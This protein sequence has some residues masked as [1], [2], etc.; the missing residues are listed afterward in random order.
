MARAT[1][2]DYYKILGVKTDATH[3]EIKKRYRQLAL[4]HHPDQNNNSKK[5]EENFKILSEAHQTLINKKKRREYDLS[6]TR[7]GSAPRRDSWGSDWQNSAYGNY[8]SPPG[9]ESSRSNE[10]QRQRAGSPFGQGFAE[11]DVPP[12]PNRPMGGFDL[13]FMIEVPLTLVALGGTLPYSY[14]K[15]VNCSHCEGTGA[16]DRKPCPECEGKRQVVES[17]TIDVKIPPGVA[18]QYTLRVEHKGGEGRNGGP[19]GHLYLK[20]CT[21][22]HPRFKRIKNDIYADI[23]IPLQLAAQGGPLQVETLN[24]H[25]T[26]YVEEGTLTGEEYRIPGEGAA[27]MWGNKRGD[28]V[29]RFNISDN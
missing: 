25:R 9:A 23:S 7:Q 14:E 5:S 24:S 19:P 6:R 10:R 13:Q 12:D 15:Y 21:Q 28:F 26:I 18:D 16:V 1:R 2:R 20:L 11:E 8:S 17:V 4:K 27:I 29:V 22:A 3:E